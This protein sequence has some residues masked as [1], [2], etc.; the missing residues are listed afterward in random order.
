MEVFRSLKLNMFAFPSPQ[1]C[2]RP[3]K[4]ELDE[5]SSKIFSLNNYLKMI[6]REYGSC[7]IWI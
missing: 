4:K 3:E 7:L 1:R 5:G 2:C 6:S